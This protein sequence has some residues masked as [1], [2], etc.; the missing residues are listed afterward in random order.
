MCSY[1]ASRSAQTPHVPGLDHRK[2]GRWLGPDHLASHPQPELY[3]LSSQGGAS[4][5]SLETRSFIESFNKHLCSDDF[6]AMHCCGSWRWSSKQSK[7]P[8][9]S[10]KKKAVSNRMKYT[11]CQRAIHAVERRISGK[12]DED[13]WGKRELS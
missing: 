5:K 13:Y 7:S 9:S 2:S 11:L 6:H 12:V 10:G 3:L 1:A 4:L 8:Q